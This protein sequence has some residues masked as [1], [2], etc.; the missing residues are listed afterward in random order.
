MIST[1]WF[2]R[3]FSDPQQPRAVSKGDQDKKVAANLSNG[4][5]VIVRYGD[6]VYLM[7]SFPKGQHVVRYAS[8]ASDASPVGSIMDR[9]IQSVEPPGSEVLQATKRDWR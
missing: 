4:H 3:N 5:K 2:Q 9:L 8:F 1:T 6:V 7:N